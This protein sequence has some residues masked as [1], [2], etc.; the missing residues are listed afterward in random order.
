M[1][2]NPD[3][4]VDAI[5]KVGKTGIPIFTNCV[6]CGRPATKEAQFKEEGITVIEKYC[7][8]CIKTE[9]LTA[10]MTFYG[11]RNEG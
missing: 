5:P 7:E 11:R 8:N 2:R 4:V 1:V 9:N 10:L 6:H 3:Q